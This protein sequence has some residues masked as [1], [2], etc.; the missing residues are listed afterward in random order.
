MVIDFT[1]KK[2]EIFSFIQTKQEINKEQ[3]LL[4]REQTE[5]PMLQ[6]LIANK[7]PYEQLW[8]TAYNFESMSDVWLNG[9]RFTQAKLHICIFSLD[10]TYPQYSD[11]LRL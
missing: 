10:Q 3:S 6:T 9:R 8:N 1:W 4:D 5:F 11:L 7:Q 2:Q